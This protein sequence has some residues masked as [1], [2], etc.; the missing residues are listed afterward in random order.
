MSQ[1]VATRL[2]E[3][4]LRSYWHPVTPAKDLTDRPLAARLLDERIVLYRAGDRV[5]CFQDLCIHR[6]TPLSLGWI[7]DGCLVCAYHG[8]SYAADGLCVRIPSL[9]PE[10]GIPRKARA[11][12]YHCVERYGL[13]W[14]CLDEPTAPLPEFEEYG[15]PEYRPLV[16][17]YNWQAN[18]ARVIENFLD[19]SHFPFVHAGVLGDRDRPLY[20]PVGTGMRDGRLHVLVDDFRNGNYRRYRVD[21]PFTLHLITEKKDPALTDRYIMLFTCCPVS[22]RETRHFFV[23]V[24]NFALDQSDDM[25]IER[26]GLVMKQDQDVVEAQR[27]EEL[28]LDLSEELHLKGPDT[29]AVEYRKALA[30]LGVEW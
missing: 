11:T 10:Q 17:E 18:A 4:V 9:P 25:F 15:N 5:V 26:N 1:P 13:V 23:A 7:E 16:I 29:A 8:W 24:R 22:A 19:H 27:P 30:R 3:S 14:V 12:A 28:P 21:L 6:G 2:S 20:P